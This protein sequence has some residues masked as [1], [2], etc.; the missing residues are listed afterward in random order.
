MVELRHAPIPAGRKRSR[1]K[2]G[3]RLPRLGLRPLDPEKRL[4][5]PRP[6]K[7]INEWAPEVQWESGP[8]FPVTD[9]E[10]D[11]ILQLLGGDLKVIL[12]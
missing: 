1:R 6:R 5:K 2:A 9:A 7:I 8:D 3:E 10:L 4:L 11:A 12:A